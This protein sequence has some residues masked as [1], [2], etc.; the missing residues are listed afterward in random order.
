MMFE[1]HFPA[2]VVKILWVQ[3]H[4]IIIKTSFSQHASSF[5]LLLLLGGVSRQADPCLIAEQQ[6]TLLLLKTSAT[7]PRDQHQQRGQKKM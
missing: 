2:E 6:S 3:K 7:I 1:S 4:I 5:L